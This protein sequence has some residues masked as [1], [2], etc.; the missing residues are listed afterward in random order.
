MTRLTDKFEELNG[1]YTD[2]RT[3]RYI[4]PK[5]II[6]TWG[7]VQN[8]ETLLNEKPPQVIMGSRDICTLTNVSGQPHAAILLDFG[9]EIA[10][11]LRIFA[12][13]T[14]VNGEKGYT[15]LL[16]RLGESVGEVLTPVG[17]HGATSD[18][19]TREMIMTTPSM[20]ANETPETGF[21][22]AYIELLE[23]AGITSIHK[24]PGVLKY[25]DLEYKGS[26]ESNDALLNRIWNVSAYT[27][28]LNM[29]E[30]IWDGIKRDRLV[31][32]GDLHPEALT[33]LATFG[34]CDV[35]EKSLDFVRDTTPDG[36]WMNGIST[37]SLWWVMIHAEL[38]RATGN[39]AYLKEQKAKMVEILSRVSDCVDENGGEKMPHWALLDWPNEANPPAKHAGIQGM[40]KMT[41]EEGAH[42]LCMMGEETLADKCMATVEKMKNHVPDVNGSKQ[43]AAMLALSGLGDAKKLNDEVISIGGSKK[44][45][46]FFSYYLLKAKAL[47]GDYV[48]ALEALREYYGGMLKMG[49]TTFW[50]DFDIEWMEN[51]APIDDLV[52]EGMN[53]IHGDFGNYCY[54]NF[55]HSLC[56][57]WSSGPCP[58]LSHYVLGVRP[59][60][61]DTYVIKPELGDLEWAKGTYPTAKGIISVSVKKTAEGQKVEYTAPEGI[62]IIDK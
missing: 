28:H 56:H 14:R 11:S 51:S 61:A 4:T 35:I 20:S 59:V 37:Y 26:F 48:G 34:D 30:Y 46:T 58:Y 21:R 25:R 52:P 41:L 47:A 62:K 10:G 55:R 2:P 17:Q 18:H 54:R 19:A 53:D 57:G 44:F 27:A 5:R 1:Q 13:L 9:V 31:W 29:Q 42:M 23:D 22:F 16:I 8:A 39:L 32:I 24:A 49:A 40:L 15:H 7:D 3:R 33:I 36:A 50:E 38:F 60:S 45:S 6:K 12:H 43:A